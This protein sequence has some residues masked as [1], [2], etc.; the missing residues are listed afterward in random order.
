[1]M[2]GDRVGVYVLLSKY[3]GLGLLGAPDRY[4]G[5]DEDRSPYC[6]YAVAGAGTC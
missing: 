5:R 1:M 2:A 4:S 3:L 6:T